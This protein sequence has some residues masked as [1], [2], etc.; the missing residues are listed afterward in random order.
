MQRY[1]K[2]LKSC[3]GWSFSADLVGKVVE[4]EVSHPTD[5]VVEVKD[6]GL[7]WT[8]YREG[9]ETAPEV[10][11]Y[12]EGWEPGMDETVHLIEKP[13]ERK[14]PYNIPVT[15][16]NW[17]DLVRHGLLKV[18]TKVMFRGEKHKV[19]DLASMDYEFHRPIYLKNVDWVS[20]YDGNLFIRPAKKKDK[21]EDE[22]VDGVVAE[23][24]IETTLTMDNW[25]E[26]VVSG[27]LKAGSKVKIDGMEFHVINVYN[28]GTLT[29]PGSG[30]IGQVC[31]WVQEWNIVLVEPITSVEPCTPPTAAT[32]TKPQLIKTHITNDNWDEL[33]ESGRL[34]RGATVEVDEEEYQVLRVCSDGS[35]KVGS[36][37]GLHSDFHVYIEDLP[38]YLLEESKTP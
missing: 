21:T 38:V 5:V 25:N 2:V 10:Y 35:I 32:G 3:Q 6:G 33:V 28:D 4:C 20:L 31:Y 34:C 29:V 9:R 19:T 12:P 18:G 11:L 22:V 8:Q 14:R 13:K 23:H 30:D 37:L 16:E 27:R 36:P 24:G 17:K 26:L 7:L 1:C 15:T